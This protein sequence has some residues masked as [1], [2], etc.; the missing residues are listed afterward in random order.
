MTWGDNGN[1]E[2]KPCSQDYRRCQALCFQEKSVEIFRGV[3]GG[4]ETELQFERGLLFREFEMIQSKSYAWL[5]PHNSLSLFTSLKHI[6][7]TSS[8]VYRYT[9]FV[10]AE[11]LDRCDSFESINIL[12]N[13]SWPKEVFSTT[14]TYLGTVITGAL[15]IITW[16]SN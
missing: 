14:V 15:H 1:H 16:A 8:I 3:R 7:G 9:N 12:L 13:L 5:T 4:L 11:I 6:Y 2:P 10:T